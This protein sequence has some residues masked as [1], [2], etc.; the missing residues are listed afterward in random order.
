MIAL[1]CDVIFSDSCDVI[2]R[3]DVSTSSGLGEEY[4]EIP[5]EHLTGAIR[6]L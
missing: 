5:S 2:N 4:E 1:C 3:C 6:V